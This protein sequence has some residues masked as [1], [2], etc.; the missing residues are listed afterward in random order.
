LVSVDLKHLKLTLSGD[1]SVCSA[2]ENPTPGASS[3]QT[4]QPTAETAWK[5]RYDNIMQDIANSDPGERIQKTN[6]YSHEL[7]GMRESG[8]NVVME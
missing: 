4:T 7:R 8:L 5:N 1:G 2:P 3:T 6:Y